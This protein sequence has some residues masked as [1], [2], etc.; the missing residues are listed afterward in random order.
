MTVTIG[1]F[2]HYCTSAYDC[3]EEI[4]RPGASVKQVRKW[5]WTDENG[6]RS[7]LFTSEQ[8]ARDDAA[9]RGYEMNA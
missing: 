4:A 3:G 5:I 8:D 2:D 6:R 7:R 1:T 9:R